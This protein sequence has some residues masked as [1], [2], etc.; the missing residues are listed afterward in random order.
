MTTQ[1]Q[2]SYSLVFMA[3]RRIV[4]IAG[5]DRGTDWTLCGDG[6]WHRFYRCGHYYQF[7]DR[8]GDHRY[9]AGDHWIT[10]AAARDVLK[11]FTTEITKITEKFFKKSL[12]NLC[13]LW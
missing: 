12:W 11:N 10:V 4:E 3:L 9:S 2:K 5:G 13:S 7:N 8:W 1:S 6:A